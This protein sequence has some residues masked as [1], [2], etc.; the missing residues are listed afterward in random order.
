MKQDLYI[1]I[2]Y[3]QLNQYMYRVKQF[4]WAIISFFKAEIQRA[5]LKGKLCKNSILPF[6][7]QACRPLRPALVARQL[8]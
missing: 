5:N 1:F 2:D 4:L 8:R 3:W 6:F 7:T